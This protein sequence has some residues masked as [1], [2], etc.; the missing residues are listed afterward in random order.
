MVMKRFLLWLYGGL[1]IRASER[2]FCMIL[3]I[4][5]PSGVGFFA[6]C[7]AC[8]SAHDTM[9]SALRTGRESGFAFP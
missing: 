9:S 3:S 7:L 8:T 2:Q 5:S 6:S 4:S 1:D